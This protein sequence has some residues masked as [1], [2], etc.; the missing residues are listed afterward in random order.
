VVVDTVALASNSPP[1]ALST[2]PEKPVAS[3]LIASPKI[4]N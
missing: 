1:L 4:A 3:N 2:K